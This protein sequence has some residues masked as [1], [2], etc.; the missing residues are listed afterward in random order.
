[1]DQVHEELKQPITAPSVDSGATCNAAAELASDEEDGSSNGLP[2]EG[3]GSPTKGSAGSL[4]SDDTDYET[5]DSGLSSERGSVENDAGEEERK[6]WKNNRVQPDEKTSKNARNL[7]KK[8]GETEVDFSDTTSEMDP[9][10]GTEVKEHK[11][12]SKP[13]S[14]IEPT[15]PKKPTEL[16]SIV[17]DVFDGRI[18]SSVQ[19]LTCERVSLKSYLVLV[20]LPSPLPGLLHPR[21][22]PGPVS[23]HSLKGPPSSDPG[24]SLP[25][26]LVHP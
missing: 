5:C 12:R 18:L 25:R 16:K 8:E 20:I 6:Q 13:T 21:D 4:S 17:S 26:S 22:I 3:G 14:E 2:A 11:S 15:R 10:Q 24:Q 19:C 23:A 9:L 1:M 7:Q